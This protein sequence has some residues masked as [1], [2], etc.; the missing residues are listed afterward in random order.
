MAR[1]AHAR[2]A[3]RLPATPHARVWPEA[4]ADDAVEDCA[5]VARP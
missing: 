4:D 5:V 1:Y 2:F 3:S